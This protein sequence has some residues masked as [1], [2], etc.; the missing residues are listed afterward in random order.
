MPL[1]ETIKEYC[2]N[3]ELFGTAVGVMGVAYAGQALR[4]GLA[5]GYTLVKRHAMTTLEIPVSDPS[6]SWMM[7]WLSKRPDASAHLSVKTSF[8]QL[9]SG[10][11]DTSFSFGPSP[12]LHYIWYNKL[13]IKIERT[14]EKAMID[15]AHGVPYETLTLTTLGKN[16]ALVESMLQEAKETTLK[17][18]QGHTLIFKPVG[19]EW[20]QFGAPQKR[21]P[22]SSVIT[23]AGQTEKIVA[24]VKKFLNSQKWYMDRGIPY[25]RGYLLHGPPGCGK[26]S[27]INALAGA[28]EYSICI[29]EVGSHTLSDD[30]LLHFMVNAPPQSIILM[31]DIDCAFKDRSTMFED[32]RYEGM[33]GVTMSGVLN[34]LDGVIASEGRIVFMT[35]NYPDRLDKALI[36]PGRVD[37]IEEVTYCTDEQLKRSYSHFFPE[38]PECNAEIFKTNAKHVLEQISMADVQA[39]FMKY[40]NARDAL[41]N[42]SQL[43]K[44]DSNYKVFSSVKQYA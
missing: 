41:E 26:T 17:E 38:E 30:R 19:V 44:S 3:N 42:T 31:E 14:R 2:A 23:A 35:T 40:Q 16:K 5:V 27:F 24:D 34:S 11:I 43:S 13:P 6:Y 32:K 25:R 20:R 10:K 39:Y 28:L 36:R 22:L 21:R 15:Q 37:M 1:V 33:S 4:R 29:L 7:K 9:H 18:Q 12:G 8:K